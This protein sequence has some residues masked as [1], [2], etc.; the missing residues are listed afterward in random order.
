M[1]LFHG[2]FCGNFWKYHHTNS[3]RYNGS[4]LL[5]FSCSLK[6][7][8]GVKPISF[9]GLAHSTQQNKIGRACHEQYPKIREQIRQS[10]SERGLLSFLCDQLIDL[11]FLENEVDEANDTD[12][13]VNQEVD[14]VEMSQL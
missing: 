3:I 5:S 13:F 11:G 12:S 4:L 7:S 9:L 2:R 6:L 1:D 10:A 8:L 14:Q